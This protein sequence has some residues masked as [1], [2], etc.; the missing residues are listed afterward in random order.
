MRYEEIDI[1]WTPAELDRFLQEN[2]G[3]SLWHFS[4]SFV[5]NSL[6]WKDYRE[7]GGI[8]ILKEM[9][10]KLQ[11]ISEQL[12][13]PPFPYKAH[14]D[15]NNANKEIDWVLNSQNT[16]GT[17]SKRL[18]IIALIWSYFI[19]DK[20]KTHLANISGLLEWFNDKTENSEFFASFFK[21]IENLNNKKLKKLID[22]HRKEN[23]HSAA[24]EEGKDVFEMP[25]GII[26]ILFEDEAKTNRLEK[27]NW[28]KK[29]PLVTFPIGEI[30][31][32]GDFEENNRILKAGDKNRAHV[33]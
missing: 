11:K 5:D 18:S 22:R 17:P 30:L 13:K 32:I 2:Y 3:Y 24:I 12:I 10:N 29:T 26:S 33:G 28:N 21:D 27:S 15:I 1:E 8:K 4:W 19:R 9:K 25:A 16:R 31:T 20:H 14:K 23:T 7:G 6:L